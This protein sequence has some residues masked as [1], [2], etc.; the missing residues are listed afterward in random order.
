MEQFHEYYPRLD[1][2]RVSSRSSSLIRVRLHT[3]PLTGGRV[4]SLLLYARSRKTNVRIREFGA[5]IH[6]RAGIRKVDL[7]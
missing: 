1:L 6:P 5:L 7:S 2:S 3:A 4:V